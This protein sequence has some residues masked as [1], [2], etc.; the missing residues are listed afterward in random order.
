M[1]LGNSGSK[2]IEFAGMFGKSPL[3]LPVIAFGLINTTWP[4]KKPSVVK[5]AVFPVGSLG[6]MA[7]EE[8]GVR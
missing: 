2:M 6:S 7:I 5:Y 4:P 8:I 3:G 1:I